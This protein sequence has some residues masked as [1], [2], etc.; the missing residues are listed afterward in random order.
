MK[1]KFLIVLV[2]VLLVAGPVY[3]YLQKG[4]IPIDT[5]LL[6]GTPIV[7]ID[8]VSMRVEIAQTDESRIKGLSGRTKFDSADG[9][10]FVFP[11]SDYHS[12]WMKDMYFPIDILWIDE[13]LTIVGIEKN[14]DPSTYPRS[15]RPPV[16]VRYVIETNIH[17]AD[18]FNLHV[19]QKVTLPEEYID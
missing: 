4:D 10:L 13:N 12:I 9:L 2:C 17:Y 19:G 8:N 14:V 6:P 7:R 11:E 3:L 16:P 15:F 18:T 1:S 5:V